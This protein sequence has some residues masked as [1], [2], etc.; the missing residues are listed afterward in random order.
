MPGYSSWQ[1]SSICSSST[2]SPTPTS[3]KLIRGKLPVAI[4]LAI[5]RL[6]CLDLIGVVQ[7]AVGDEH[8]AAAPRALRDLRLEV[9][10]VVAGSPA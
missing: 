6:N 2:A 3:M 1:M 4:S 8:R 9:V 7:L 5:S 10:D